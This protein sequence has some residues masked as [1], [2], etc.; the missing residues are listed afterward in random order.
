MAAHEE[1]D[2]CVVVRVGI[3]VEGGDDEEGAFGCRGGFA[4]EAGALTAHAIGYAAGGDADEPGAG[5]FRKTF[6][7]PLMR[8]CDQSVLHR[9]FGGGEIAKAMEQDAE[10]LRREFAQE[11]LGGDVQQLH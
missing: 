7:R 5:I 2:E 8:G 10:H 6:V 3:E 11:M 4:I 9:I 1:Q